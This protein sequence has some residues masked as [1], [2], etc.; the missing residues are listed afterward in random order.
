MI[1][2]FLVSG[3]IGEWM[4]VDFRLLDDGF[5]NGTLRVIDPFGTVLSERNIIGGTVSSTAVQLE[6][7]LPHQVLLI[8]KDYAADYELR[9]RD[10]PELLPGETIE[11]DGSIGATQYY[12]FEA[13]AGELVRGCLD[14][15]LG[16]NGQISLLTRDGDTTPI[17]VPQVI[18]DG[19]Q[20]KRIE[21]TGTYLLWVNGTGNPDGSPPRPFRVSLDF[22]KDPVPLQLDGA[23]Q[24][25]KVTRM[26]HFGDTRM[27][28]FDGTEGSGVL[29]QM[30]ATANSTM[31]DK[32]HFRLFRVGTGTL[33]APK[34]EVNGADTNSRFWG[35]VEQGIFQY[36]YF[37]LPADDQYV[38]MLSAATPDDGEFELI[39]DVVEAT[40]SIVVDDDLADAP[41]ADTRSLQAA[42]VAA[43]AG[44]TVT[45]H[46]GRYEAPYSFLALE[47]ITVNGTDRD[48]VV[49]T[50]GFVHPV[51]CFEDGVTLVSDLTL[52]TQRGLSQ[53]GLEVY[54]GNGSVIER[55]RTQAAP[56]VVPMVSGIDLI[57]CT[58]AEVR[59]CLF[60][61]TVRSV[62]IDGGQGNQVRNNVV[63]GH[64]GKVDIDRSSDTVVQGNQFDIDYGW[65]A[66]NASNCTGTV[67]EDN[68]INITSTE[69][70]SAL[71]DSC[72]ILQDRDT[73]G[74]GNPTVVLNNRI[75]TTRSGI[76]VRLGQPGARAEI[77]RNHVVSTRDIG[78]KLLE[79]EPDW[80]EPG[81]TV[82]VRNNVL[83]GGL[84][85]QAVWIDHV[86]NFDS[87]EFINNTLRIHPNAQVV[88]GQAAVAIG[89][90]NQTTGDIPL[91]I[92]NNVF[93]GN[94]SS[95]IG[96]PDAGL[97][98]PSD[99]N[100][101]FNFDTRY[102]NG[103]TSLGASDVSADPQF[104]DGLLR[105]AAGSPAVDSGAT[106]AMEPGVPDVDF[107]GNARPTGSG[108][109]R[110]AHEQ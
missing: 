26:N 9:I 83:D 71:N 1:Q 8:A 63:A 34:T 70:G 48:T 11:G 12:R 76:H 87:V 20:I 104:V 37:K 18:F 57:V 5:M 35:D 96:L 4:S 24:A 60:T 30:L 68:D 43:D 105:V 101:F 3:D 22:V 41:S 79:I 42:L 51:L 108:V 2:P 103:A 7:A 56:G 73:A 81:K 74:D 64:N 109:D 36:D 61:D 32:G 50:T 38:V 23:G 31:T 52:E 14:E 13:P 39:V 69:A 28:W 65:T 27:F 93:Y 46:P 97:T 94:G 100:V 53:N 88:Q 44:A 21:E 59:E 99:Y 90:W 91:R 10:I 49:L 55:I 40:A 62:H 15:S 95:A 47:N 82:L 72:I 33:E 77:E 78:W 29:V 19:T 102:E 54:L 110:G 66:V 106:S 98:I 25:R 6:S 85:T 17:A 80:T 92:F 107:A 58:G 86:D 84:Y 75:S 16:F 89:R 67:V 45:I